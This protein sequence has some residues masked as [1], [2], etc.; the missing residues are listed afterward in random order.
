MAPE[1]GEPI[2]PLMVEHTLALP[3]DLDLSVAGRRPI[4]ISGQ[5]QDSPARP[6]A[7]RKNEGRRCSAWSTHFAAKIVA[8]VNSSI[9]GEQREGPAGTALLPLSDGRCAVATAWR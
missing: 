6:A 8:K 7:R 2:L 1:V 5:L 3:V 9:P 4:S